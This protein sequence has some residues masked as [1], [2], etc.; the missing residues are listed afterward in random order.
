MYKSRNQKGS[1]R[2]VPKKQPLAA[3][4]SLDILFISQKEIIKTD[5]SNNKGNRTSNF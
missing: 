3:P 5:Y 4:K 2:I 1:E